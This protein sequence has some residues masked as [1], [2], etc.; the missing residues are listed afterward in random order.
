MAETFRQI[1]WSPEAHVYILMFCI[2]IQKMTLE[3]LLED[4]DEHID[5]TE[6]RL[7]KANQK[8]NRFVKDNKS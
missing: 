2:P 7:S 8:L 1:G 5:R 6:S 3:R 4:L